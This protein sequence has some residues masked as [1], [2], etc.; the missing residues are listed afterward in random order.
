MSRQ[1]LRLHSELD[2]A[3][4]S[5]LRVFNFMFIQK[6]RRAVVISST[7][8]A[9]C[10]LS[11]RGETQPSAQRARFPIPIL[12]R[13]G[14][15][16]L[17]DVQGRLDHFALDE[18]NGRVFVSELEN[19]SLDVVDIVH[20]K[21][22][23]R[24]SGLREPQG[25][26][27]LAAKNRLLVASRGDGTVRSFST[28]NW[29]ETS[30]VD[31]GRNADNIRLNSATNTL[32]V[33]SN[34]EPGNGF[35]TSIDV[36]SLLPTSEGGK[37]AAPRSPADLL[38]NSARLA[39]IKAQIELESHPESFQIDAAHNR[40][41]VNVPDGHYVAVVQTP[42]LKIVAKWPVPFQKN[43][44]MAFDAKASRLYVV[45]RKPAMLLA[46]DTKTGKLL[47]QTPCV[48][49]ADDIYVDSAR[50]QLYIIGGQGAID[51]FQT[52]P[53]KPERLLARIPTA[54]RART[55]VWI[56]SLRLLVVAA[57]RWKNQA[58]QLLLF[59][60]NN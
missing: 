39:D 20:R 19:Q 7:G 12:Q 24:I 49:D 42:S 3:I 13:V 1:K 29:S 8:L 27:F 45:C 31:L 28:R 25:V 46:Y 5:V 2:F 35:L 51:V 22:L 53:G 14:A 44:A 17:P 33:G 6:W 4:S 41:F 50:R 36:A 47:S 26:L 11:G 9:F 34:G 52:P 58:A 57:P 15:I 16:A 30:W 59:R 10:A 23:H 38:Q 60:I 54:P 48:G 21:R 32:Y 18:K 40:V 56:P 55:G 37:L 43:F